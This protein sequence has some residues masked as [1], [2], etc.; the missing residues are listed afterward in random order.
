MAGF[1]RLQVADVILRPGELQQ[2]GDDQPDALHLLVDQADFGLDRLVTSR[3]V[4]IP[5]AGQRL[6]LGSVEMLALPAHYL[7]SCGNLHLYDP[8]SK[9]LY[10]GDLGAS[11][12]T[13]EIFVE[14]FEAYRPC[15][16]GF[17]RRYMAGNRAVR[18]WVD[19]VRELD[20]AMAIMTALKAATDPKGIMNPGKSLTTTDRTPER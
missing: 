19:M 17:H 12:G 10:T 13:D 20:P 9:I 4:G 11:M 7:H 16:E 6:A 15:M 2:L 5:D 8:V 14:D 3:L 18:L 1:H